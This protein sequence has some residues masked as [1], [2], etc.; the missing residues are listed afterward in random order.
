MEQW[1][2]NCPE[3][4]LVEARE[5]QK[6][7]HHSWKEQVDHRTEVSTH[8]AFRQLYVELLTPSLPFL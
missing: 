6:A 4:R 5:R 7:V 8:A 2:A 1:R 3:L